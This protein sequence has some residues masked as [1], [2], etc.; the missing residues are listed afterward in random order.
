[1]K[2]NSS[3]F[4]SIVDVLK[5]ASIASQILHRHAC[6]LVMGGK[7]MSIGINTYERDSKHAEKNAIENFLRSEKGRLNRCILIVIRLGKSGEVQSSKPCC[8]CVN[9]IKRHNIKRI[10]YSTYNGFEFQKG[11]EI[12]NDHIP[13][14]K[15]L[16]SL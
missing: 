3:K 16:S 15:R 14:S 8:D 9:M 7:I 5:E 2:I 11:S 13:L 6:A 1:M 4:N 12:E 10:F